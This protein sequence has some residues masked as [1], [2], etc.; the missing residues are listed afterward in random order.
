MDEG[1]NK[2]AQCLLGEQR[3]WYAC[4]VRAFSVAGALCHVEDALPRTTEGGDYRV[5]TS[6]HFQIHWTS[7]KIIMVILLA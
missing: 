2:V 6:N 3:Q 7:A 5:F 4:F 1:L